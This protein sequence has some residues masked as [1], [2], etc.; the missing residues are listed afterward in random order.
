MI[1]CTGRRCIGRSAFERAL[2]VD[3][4]M[5]TWMGGKAV[6]IAIALGNC[7]YDVNS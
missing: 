7:V 5:S 2:M 4:S 1:Y 3:M 6:R